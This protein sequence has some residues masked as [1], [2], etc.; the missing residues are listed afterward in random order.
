MV[1]SD[2]KKKYFSFGREREMKIEVKDVEES[3]KRLI[4]L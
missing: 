3:K 1:G 4:S 2:C